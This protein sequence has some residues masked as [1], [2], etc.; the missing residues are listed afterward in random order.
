M[1]HLGNDGFG[2]GLTA[3]GRAQPSPALGPQ[4]WVWG[5]GGVGILG[6][7]WDL[8]ICCRIVGS[9]WEQGMGLDWDRGIGVGSVQTHCDPLGPIGIHCDPSE[10]IGIHW[11]PLGP[12]RTHWDPSDP[13]GSIGTRCD[14]L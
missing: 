14:P 4:L 5:R 10:P 12:T 6:S 1:M 13:L 11:G 3:S 8:G 9:G 7:G 2:A